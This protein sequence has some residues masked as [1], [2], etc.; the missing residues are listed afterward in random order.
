MTASSASPPLSS[1]IRRRSVRSG[2]RAIPLFW[3]P[4][5]M[6]AQPSNDLRPF[7]QGRRMSSRFSRNAGQVSTTSGFPS[8]GRC[9]ARARSGPV[10]TRRE[11]GERAAPGPAE[12]LEIVDAPRRTRARVR[13]AP[14]LAAA[15]GGKARL[16]KRGRFGVTLGQAR[17]KRLPDL[18]IQSA[19][20]AEGGNRPHARRA[21]PCGRPARPTRV[22]ALLLPGAAC[23]SGQASRSRL[24]LSTRPSR[25]AFFAPE[26]S[27]SMTRERRPMLRRAIVF[28][29]RL[30][31]WPE[32]R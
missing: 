30:P 16:A 22:S 27:T 20:A 5:R 24:R 23:R 1:R 7:L 32:A 9:I 13:L 28:R 31:C 14:E 29:K 21:S 4:C 11:A 10:R 17:D 19:V 25:P 15:G 3:S 8:A 2:H 18:F 26:K 12:K 6:P